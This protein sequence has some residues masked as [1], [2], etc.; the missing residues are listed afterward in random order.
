MPRTVLISEAALQWLEQEAERIA[1]QFGSSIA[2]EFRDRI[3][4]AI[5]NLADYP[6][7]AKRGAIPGTRT[8]TVHRRTIL[9]IVERNGALVV[10]AARG[11]RQND[12]YNPHEAYSAGDDEPSK[13][14]ETGGGLKV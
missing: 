8:I 5:E 10:A 6:H 4:T 1:G 7:M 3:K 12:A 11:H 13:D 9:T 14:P 2:N